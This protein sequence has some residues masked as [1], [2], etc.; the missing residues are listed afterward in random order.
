MDYRKVAEARKSIREFTDKPVSGELK[1]ALKKSFAECRRLV[2]DIKTEI[3]ILDRSE[4]GCLQGNAG[5]EGLTFEAPAYL[6]LL[7][8]V[9]PGYLENVGYMNEDI[10]LHMTD[11]GLDS[12]W[13]T[14]D[15]DPALRAALKIGDDR[16]VAAITAFGYGKKERSLTRLHIRSISDVDVITREGH[17]A[18]KISL[19]QMV[20]G[21]AW[22][23]EA[24]L[25]EMYIDDGLRDALYAASYAPTF[26]NRQS[27]RLLLADGKA[28]LVKMM[29]SMTGELD[30]RLNCGAVM[31]NF[32]AA[33]DERR[34]FQTKWTLGSLSGYELPADC[35]IVGY[36]SL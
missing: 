27:F 5:Y 30:A 6:L 15:D 4:C 20:Y 23:K 36:C 17:L 29:D 7:S 9:K 11:M 1:E 26:L 33:L 34:P 2:P 19:A 25:D 18:P 14:V 3:L 32:A 24:D 10:I 8:E 13:L 21:D 31:L 12:C 28:I 16:K 22:G 35:E